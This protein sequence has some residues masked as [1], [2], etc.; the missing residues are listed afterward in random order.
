MW[1]FATCVRLLLHTALAITPKI[2]LENEGWVAWVAGLGG[3]PGWLAWV[4]G[5]QG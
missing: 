2:L 5:R 4:A 1:T 3:W